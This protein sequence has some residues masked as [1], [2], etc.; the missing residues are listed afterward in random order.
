MLPLRNE[1]LAG[2]R[3]FPVSGSGIKQHNYKNGKFNL[4]RVLE[5]LNKQ[6]PELQ[7]KIAKGTIEDNEKALGIVF[8]FNNDKTSELT[9]I[10]FKPLEVTVHDAVKQ[11]LDY[12]A[13][14]S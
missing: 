1:K 6:F 3:L 5:V 9:G 8:E 13:S 7:G 12:K 2:E 14:F 4:Q 11:I 10:E